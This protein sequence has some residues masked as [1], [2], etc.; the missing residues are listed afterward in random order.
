MNNAELRI[1]VEPDKVREFHKGR[2]ELI[3]IGELTVGRATF[4]PG[5]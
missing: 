5:W 2:L 4:E 3:K 1:L